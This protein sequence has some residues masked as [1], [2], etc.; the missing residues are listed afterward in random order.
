M[1]DKTPRIQRLRAE[2]E[3]AFANRGDLYRLVLD[4]LEEALDAEQAES[5]LASA[6][7]MRGREVARTAFA[8]FGAEDALAIGEAFLDVSPDEGQMYPAD[9]TRY[10]NGIEFKVRRCPLKDSWVNAGLSEE[11]I[12]TLCRIAG[13]FDRGLF[14]ETGVR[15]ENWTW[16]PGDGPGCC[17]I[18][19]LD[20]P[21]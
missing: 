8:R 6:I 21:A 1:T 7:E 14:E 19:L 12:A 11:R 2:L 16:Q 20:N 4:Q 17:R 9:V 3:A 10:D 5:I 18:R 13:A 15:F